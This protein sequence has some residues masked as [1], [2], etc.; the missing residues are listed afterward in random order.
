MGTA[1]M[2]ACAIG[3]NFAS[4]SKGSE[5]WSRILSLAHAETV[6][7]VVGQLIEFAEVPEVPEV[8]EW[9]EWPEGRGDRSD[10]VPRAV[11]Q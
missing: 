7:P 2:G 6:R 1:V 10:P 4:P 8:L 3:M 9:L 11:P 5:V